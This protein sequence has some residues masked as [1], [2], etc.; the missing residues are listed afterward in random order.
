MEVF[1]LQYFFFLGSKIFLVRWPSIELGKHV[2]WYSY[3]KL[4]KGEK[5]KNKWHWLSIDMICGKW[6]WTFIDWT[7][8]GSHVIVGYKSGQWWN[9][10]NWYYRF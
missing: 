6:S 9:R 2:Y 1:H 8:S 10:V 7:G 3:E 5:K 4:L